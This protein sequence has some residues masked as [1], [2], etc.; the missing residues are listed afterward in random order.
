MQ[1]YSSWVFARGMGPSLRHN[2]QNP[3]LLLYAAA[4]L[5]HIA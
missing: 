3:Q 4:S 1:K 2:P 5:I